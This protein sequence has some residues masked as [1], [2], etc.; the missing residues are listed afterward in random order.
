MSQYQDKLLINKCMEKVSTHWN[1]E[2][3]VQDQ[4]TEGYCAFA[5]MNSVLSSI[6][7]GK[8][9]L[10]MPE[11]PRPTALQTMCDTL[12]SHVVDN[13]SVKQDFPNIIIESIKVIYI[14]PS[15]ISLNDFEKLMKETNPNNNDY[16]D[17]KYVYYI[18]NFNRTPLFFCNYSWFARWRKWLFS[19]HFSPIVSYC[20][21]NDTMYLLIG[22]VNRKKYG[23]YLARSDR[24][25]EALA[26]QEYGGRRR[27]II[28]IQVKKNFDV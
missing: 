10:E 26:C 25:Y 14:N 27:G 11:F 6:F 24:L 13:V 9:Y 18:A 21:D 7:D 8:L 15:E 22:D 20:N 3:D 23:N 4:H 16:N 12:S 2:R 1:L 19:G 17:N 5:A 28:R